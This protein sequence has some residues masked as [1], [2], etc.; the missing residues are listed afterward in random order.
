[1]MSSALPATIGAPSDFRQ[2]GAMFTYIN[3]EVRKRLIEEGRLIRLNEEG[4]L[5]DVH[6]PEAPG[7]L[8]INL[9]G[10]IPLPVI[11]SW[12]ELLPWPLLKAPHRL[13]RSRHR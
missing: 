12:R 11:A 8:A 3:P 10:P 5:I 9:M 4:Q 1:M 13:S 7:E 2:D 6:S